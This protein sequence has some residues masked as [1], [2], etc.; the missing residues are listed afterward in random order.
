MRIV[1]GY[2]PFSIGDIFYTIVLIS[3]VYG[4]IKLVVRIIR[5]EAQWKYVGLRFLK[6]IRKLLWVYIWFN[7]V[8]GLNYYREGIT[9]QLHLKVEDYSTE[10]LCNLTNLLIAKTNES[11]LAISKDSVLPEQSLESIYRQASN[12]YNFNNSYFSFLQYKN[13][14][15]KKSLYTFLAPYFGFTGYYNPFSGEA[16]L[17]DDVPRILIPYTTSHEIAHQLG[18]ASETEANFV[19]YLAATNSS[20]NYFKYSTYLDLYR[21][22]RIELFMRNTVPDNNNKLDSLVKKDLR[23]I[24]HF[25]LKERNNISGKVMS[26]YGMY[27]QA[28]NQQKGINSYD[29][30][31]SLLIAYYKQYGK[32]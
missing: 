29:D 16:Q 27:L 5:K 15:V 21:Y 17:R 12:N 1:T 14:D 25:F 8:W 13:K 9:A 26:L 24:N 22:A 31:I 18:Y 19:G 4:I 6:F 20:N 2:I 7:L 11:R 28:N 32:I 23:N 3:V 10:D 30:V